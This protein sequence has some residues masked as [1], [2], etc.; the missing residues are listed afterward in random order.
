[1]AKKKYPYL[2]EGEV[3]RVIVDV[4]KSAFE[5][6]QRGE[7]VKGSLGMSG[8]L[9]AD[10]TAYPPQKPRPKPAKVL[11]QPHGKVEISAERVKMTLTVKHSER[12]SPS[13]TIRREAYDASQ[14][15][16]DN[17]WTPEGWRPFDVEW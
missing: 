5:R 1:M 16:E 14:F 11:R 3:R 4:S 7:R 15:V 13:E 6:M 17:D 10:F 12:V 8:P 9:A 2:V